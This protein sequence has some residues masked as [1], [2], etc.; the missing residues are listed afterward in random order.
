MGQGQSYFT[1]EEIQD[2]EDCTFLSR[3]QINRARKNFLKY[4]QTSDGQKMRKE[5]FLKIPELQ[6]NPF[7]PRIAE[8]FSDDGSGDLS[9]EDFLD[10]V[11]IFSSEV[12]YS[13]VFLK[14]HYVYYLTYV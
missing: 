10:F 6:H 1:E 14:I 13:F 11:S 12:I 9:F 4:R 3:T 2:L 7:A 5:D 8:V